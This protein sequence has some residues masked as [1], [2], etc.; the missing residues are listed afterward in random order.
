MRVKI[1]KAK[2]FVPA[3]NG[4]RDLP[5]AEQIKVH[6]RFLAPGEKQKYYYSEPL[7]L[8]GDK[9]EKPK[10]RWQQDMTGHVKAVVTSIEN[11]AIEYA[12]GT[13]VDIDTAGKLYSTQGV[14]STLVGEIEAYM[15]NADPEVQSDTDPLE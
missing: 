13:A 2:T 14:S 5:E 9:D 7:E 4:N 6:H 12:D 1:E 3:W 10:M 15:I 11:Y 8:S